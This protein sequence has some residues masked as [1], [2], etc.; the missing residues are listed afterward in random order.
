MNYLN[1]SPNELGLKDVSRKESEGYGKITP[2]YKNGRISHF[3]YP[4]STLSIG[5]HITMMGDYRHAQYQAATAGPFD[6][7]EREVSHPLFGSTRARIDM[8]RGNLL[9]G[10]PEEV[11]TI[12][13]DAFS[14]LHG[15]KATAVSQLNAY[16]YM[17]GS[18][19]GEL[20]YIAREA[21]A[22]QQTFEM[23]YDPGRL[24]ADITA[25]RQSRW[26]PIDQ[27]LIYADNPINVHYMHRARAHGR[28]RGRNTFDV[29]YNKGAIYQ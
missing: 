17:T 22:V 27:S 10:H 18:D 23:G 11:K 8:W 21:P 12:G 24:I 6:I 4:S 3:R 16:M 29:G 28:V 1:I 5:N 15:P 7:P 25:K 14:S 13:Y 19:H 20:T 9:G 2:V 26:A